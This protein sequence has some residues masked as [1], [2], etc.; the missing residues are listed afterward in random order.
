MNHDVV[1][2]GP[3]RDLT[4]ARR[5]VK[6]PS[7]GQPPARACKAPGG[8]VQSAAH[9]ARHREAVRAGAILY[10][11]CLEGCARHG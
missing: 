8:S 4:E 11:P 10:L 9:S 5:S 3:F 6:C 7:C 1:A 2:A